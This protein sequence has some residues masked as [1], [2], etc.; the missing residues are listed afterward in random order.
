MWCTS[1]HTW[2]K[3]AFNR[4]ASKMNTRPWML[5]ARLHQMPDTENSAPPLNQH[6]TTLAKIR[7]NTR[8]GYKPG[9][10]DAMGQKW[11]TLLGQTLLCSHEITHTHKNTTFPKFQAHERKRKTAQQQ[12]RPIR[13]K[14]LAKLHTTRFLC[15]F[16]RRCAK[17]ETTKPQHNIHIKRKNTIGTEQSEKPSENTKQIAITEAN[18][19]TPPQHHLQLTSTRHNTDVLNKLIRFVVSFGDRVHRRRTCRCHT[20]RKIA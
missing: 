7:G 9:D 4:V 5:H 11:R 8:H 13:K 17:P 16:L 15:T 2:Y 10:V 6:L 20:E 19:R 1:T 12:Q 14:T 18:N 3:Q